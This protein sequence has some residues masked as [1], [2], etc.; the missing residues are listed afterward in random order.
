M[1]WLQIFLLVLAWSLAVTGSVMG[2]IHGAWGFSV[3]LIALAAVIYALFNSTL[4][5]NYHRS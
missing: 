5:E 4:P 2:I 3:I 1:T